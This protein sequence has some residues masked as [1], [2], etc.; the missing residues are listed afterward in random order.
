LKITSCGRCTQAEWNALKNRDQ[1][2][3]TLQR[4]SRSTPTTN[5]SRN[6]NC[7]FRG[8]LAAAPVGRPRARKFVRCR[9]QQTKHHGCGRVDRR[10]RRRRGP[11][12]ARAASAS[13]TSRSRQPNTRFLFL[14]VPQQATTTRTAV[15]HV[16]GVPKNA[17]VQRRLLYQREVSAIT[18]F[19]TLRARG[20]TSLSVKRR[21]KIS[22]VRLE[23]RSP[24]ENHKNKRPL[25]E[26]MRC[27]QWTQPR[28][29]P[30][31]RPPWTQRRFP[32]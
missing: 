29:R 14:W 13:K 24:D 26:R 12:R 25:V 11:A 1:C 30:I 15:V 18:L 22:K 32:R 8:P 3:L 4:R 5:P 27:G 6:G 9:R 31:M 2:F 23:D 7:R 16:P 19:S 10:R 21:K 17:R 28:W 20:W